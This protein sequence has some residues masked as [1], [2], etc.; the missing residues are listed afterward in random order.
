MCGG[1]LLLQ[2]QSQ[3]GDEEPHSGVDEK[4]Q[5]Q[6]PRLLLSMQY[7]DVQLGEGVN[8]SI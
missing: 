8:E 4:W 5:T 2:V 7:Q 6:N 1:N 3:T